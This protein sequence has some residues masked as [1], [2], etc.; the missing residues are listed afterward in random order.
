MNDT[1]AAIA[2]PNI[3]SAISIIRISGPKSFDIINTLSKKI[4]QKK[5][6]T[7][8]KEYIYEKDHVI[9]E[10][11]VLK[12]VSP[13]SYTGE[14]LVE[15]NCHGGILLTN[16]ILNLILDCGARLAENGEFTKRAFLNNK[17]SLRQANSIN[18]LVFAKTESS[19]NLASKGIIN[20]NSDFFNDIKE[21]L[22]FLIGKIEVN[23]DYPEYDDVEDITFEIL[24]KEV[25]E[26]INNL[27]EVITKFKSISYLYNGLNIVIVGK[28]NVGKSSLLNALLK[29]DKAIV[30]NIKGTTRDLVSESINIDGLL[31]N[32]ID[33]AG[34]RNS[35]N[36]IEN[37]GINKTFESINEADLILFLID[38]SKK[39]SKKEEEIF[40]L[41]KSK[42]VIVVKNKSD[43][44]INANKGLSG[45]NI[46]ALKKDVN[47]LI[48][49]IKKVFK[50]SDFDVASNLSIC[51]ENE[52]NF[53]KD[54]LRVLKKSFHDSQKKVPLDLIVVD[55]TTA[56]KK[57]CSFLGLSQELDIID[58]MF[59]NFCLG[60]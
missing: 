47:D 25:S 20:S 30:S 40:N 27:D 44:K 41:V 9:D 52:L 8:S 28:P 16:K 29:K 33:T 45:V 37:I 43:L 22:F 57:I 11:I 18:N 15:I 2:T 5:G 55:L 21:K 39:I 10:V 13:R 49:E 34:I 58:K 35:K 53:V 60:K 59:K 24:E 17:I 42:K 7:F 46:S 3:N 38:D 26:I 4:V 48:I 31:L 54:I 23:I 19:V 36:E 1:I 6:Y 51:S 50:K 56:Y 32:F 14:D 12:F